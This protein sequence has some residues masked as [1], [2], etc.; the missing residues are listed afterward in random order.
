[1][2]SPKKKLAT[3]RP[4]KNRGPAIFWGKNPSQIRQISTKNKLLRS[5]YLDD[6]IPP[7]ASCQYS[8]VFFLTCSQILAKSSCGVSPVHVSHE[9]E[10]KKTPLELGELNSDG[11]KCYFCQFCIIAKVAMINRQI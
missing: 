4:K 3:W 10:E 1:V 2:F 7:F 6:Y 9:I 11:T 8:T 5:P